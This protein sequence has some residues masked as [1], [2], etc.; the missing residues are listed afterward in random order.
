MKAW[1]HVYCDK[2]SI[3]IHAYEL[4]AYATIT[5]KRAMNGTHP[6]AAVPIQSTGIMN[7]SANAV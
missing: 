3:N 1:D 7:P 5:L 6:H 2:Y 4:P